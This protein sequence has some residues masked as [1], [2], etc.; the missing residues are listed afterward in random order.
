MALIYKTIQSTLPNEEGQRLYHPRAVYTGNVDTTQI[1]REVAAYSSLTPGDVKNPIDTLVT[2][3]TPHLRASESVP[4]DGLAPF[5]QVMRSRGMGAAPAPE[6]T[7]TQAALRGHFTP[8][9]TRNQ[10]RTVA[11][12]SLLTGVKCVPWKGETTSTGTTQPGG[13]GSQG[14]EGEDPLG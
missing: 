5:R 14:G 9:S 1:A 7:P 2:V 8:A 4:P 6:V 12:R 13:G 11:T 10:D 3:M